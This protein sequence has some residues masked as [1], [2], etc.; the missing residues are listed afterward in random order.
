MK[1][2]VGK[3][4]NNRIANYQDIFSEM[5]KEFN[6]EDSFFIE[7]IKNIWADVVGKILS[8]HSYPDRVYKNI[9]FVSVDHNIYANELVMMK[10]NIL[11]IINNKTNNNII[12]NIKFE[13][14]ISKWKK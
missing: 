6:F 11:E 2:R 10:D 1:F 3:N 4:R 7:N 9:L 13:V 5:V 14:K 12:K 8:A